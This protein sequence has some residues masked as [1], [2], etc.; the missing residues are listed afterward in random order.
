MP[1][2]AAIYHFTRGSEKR[3]IINHKELNKLKDFTQSQGFIVEEVFCDRSLNVNKR[4]EL[5]RFL[6]C[7][8][9]F[10]ILITKDFYHINHHTMN[11]INILKELRNDGIE[12]KT[13]EN[14]PFN[15]EDA[16]FD[17]N[18]KVATYCCHLRNKNTFKNILAVQNDIL[19]LFIKRKTNWILSGQYSD[20]SQT[21][22]NDDQPH[23]YE[24]LKN[25][26]KY[27]LILVHNLNDIHWRTSKFFKIREQYKLDI[28][29]L[30]DGFLKHNEENKN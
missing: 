23:L 14:G 28:Y 9:K 6:S 3:S 8:Y 22:N 26:N 11:C 27:D 5:N 7:R 25:A 12:I 17:K 21:L 1:K 29:S 13:I 16:P 18:L 10:N 2:K 15:L 4:Y 30:Q 24:L 20:E 19:K